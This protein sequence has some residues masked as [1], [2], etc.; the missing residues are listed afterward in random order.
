MGVNFLETFVK[1]VKPD[2]G[3][4]KVNLKEVIRNARLVD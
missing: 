3:L 1:I 4:E 2:L